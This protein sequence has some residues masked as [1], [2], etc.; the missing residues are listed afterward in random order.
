M[1]TPEEF[2]QGHKRLVQWMNILRAAMNDD[3]DCSLNWE[4]LK[5]LHQD[6]RAF[7]SSYELWM[8]RKVMIAELKL[9]A[10]QEQ[11]V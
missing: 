6:A 3:V 11:R 8:R 5:E 4:Q 7:T 10:M 2:G 9:K 1:L